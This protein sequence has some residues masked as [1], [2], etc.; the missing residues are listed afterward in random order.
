MI[1]YGIKGDCYMK[2]TKDDLGVFSN[3]VQFLKLSVGYIIA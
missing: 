2:E 3:N 1:N